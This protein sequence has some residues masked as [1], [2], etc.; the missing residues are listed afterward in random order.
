MCYVHFKDLD[1][2]RRFIELGRGTVDFLPLA[3]ILREGGFDGWIVV[4]LD[5]TSLDPRESSRMNMRQLRS[6]LTA[7]GWTLD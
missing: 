4:D 7:A 5:Y 2:N 1:D 6:T 3:R